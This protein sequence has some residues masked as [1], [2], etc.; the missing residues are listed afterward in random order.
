GA[1]I[2][3]LSLD[4]TVDKVPLLGAALA[5]PDPDVRLAGV[6]GLGRARPEGARAVTAILLGALDDADH[7]VRREAAQALGMAGTKDAALTMA[8][9]LQDPEPSVRQQLAL[10]VGVLGDESVAPALLVALSDPEDAVV[11]AAATALGFLGSIDAIAGLS[12]L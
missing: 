2:A 12:A 8:A 1:A 3:L 7:R 11:A 9:H 6:I 4:V 10:A 5:D